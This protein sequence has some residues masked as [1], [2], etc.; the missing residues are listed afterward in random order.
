M[1]AQGICLKFK[2]CNFLYEGNL[3]DAKLLEHQKFHESEFPVNSFWFGFD[4]TLPIGLF[5]SR[6]GKK[7]E[8]SGN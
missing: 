5:C 4:I 1:T 7:L 3:D 2:K 6:C 8:F